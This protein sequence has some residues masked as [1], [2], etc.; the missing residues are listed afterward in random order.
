MSH[1][2]DLI[3]QYKY[4]I[5]FPLAAIEGPIVSLAVG[6]LIYGGYLQFVPAY[7]ILIFGDLI[8]DTIYY[9]IGRYG[10]HKNLLAKYGS[11]LGK[12]WR[13]HPG[14]TMFLSKLAYGLSTP[15]LISAGLTNMPLK[16]FWRYSVPVTLFQYAVILTLGYCLGHSY[17]LAIGYIKNAGIAIAGSVILLVVAYLIISR[18]ARKQIVELEKSEQ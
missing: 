12:L 4:L 16:K 17:Q 14:K 18:Y 15:F 7:I 2:I 11:A 8:P 9:Y 10:N 13:D 1:L 3:I 6:F 5:L